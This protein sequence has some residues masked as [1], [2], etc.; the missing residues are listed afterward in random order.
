MPRALRELGEAADE[1]RLVRA[2]DHGETLL[3][4]LAA[5]GQLWNWID[6]T[7]SG[8][9]VPLEHRAGWGYDAVRVPLYLAWSN[10]LTH[11]AVAAGLRLLDEGAAPGR[12]VVQRTAGG[13][14]EAESDHP[15]FLALVSSARCQPL[16]DWPAEK[17]SYYPDTLMVLAGTALR[18]GGCGRG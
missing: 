1:P 18:E 5:V 10:H 2:A 7:A 12:V 14:P 3:A 17:R 8:F 13:R 6:V 15:G 9:T 4:E 11:P 16:P